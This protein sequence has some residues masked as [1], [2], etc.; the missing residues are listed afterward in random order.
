MFAE[1]SGGY[2]HSKD[3]FHWEL[4]VTSE[5]KNQEAWTP[6]AFVMN[7]TLYWHVN[8]DERV[9]R[10]TDPGSGHWELATS[11]FERPG[12]DQTF[13]Y[14]P[15]SRRLFFYVGSHFKDPITGVEYD[16]GTWKWKGEPTAV[17]Q[18]NQ[19]ENGWEVRS[20][21]NDPSRGLP[22]C[23]EG[24]W[25]S[26]LGSTLY[27][28]YA[29]PVVE[30]KSYCDAV[31]TAPASSPLGPFK[32]QADN[33]LTMKQRGFICATGAGSIFEDFHGNLWH[34][35]CG[36]IS[37]HFVLERLLCLTPLN[38][39][40]DGTLRGW[41]GWGDWPMRLPTKKWSRPEEIKVPGVLLSYKAKVTVSSTA[42]DCKV[43]KAWDQD[44]C[45]GCHPE[46][47]VDEEVRTWWAAATNRTGEWL[48]VD[49]GAVC[50]IT[51]I[52][53]N[54]ADEGATTVGRLPGIFYQYVV[55]GSRD[56]VSFTKILD[57]SAQTEDHPHQYC[58]AEASARFI[59]VT[60]KYTPSGKVS[61][62]GLRIFGLQPGVPAPAAATE[63]KAQRLADRRAA[64]VSWRPVPGAVGYNVRFGTGATRLWQDMIV[65]EVT[66]VTIRYLNVHQ[67]YT[68]TVDA[69]NLGGIT[70]GVETAVA[71]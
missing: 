26:R 16:P 42:S 41:N 31:Y 18:H 65:Y 61:I 22:S 8:F 37:V 44:N 69:Y 48:Q 62:S 60:N 58:E 14:Y 43:W 54:F 29:G 67:S 24:A 23:V 66:E 2:F 70:L 45:G 17:I 52:Q 39:E 64:T 71:P 33:P 25:A 40:P 12:G 50:D 27:L 49:L 35:A 3:M 20:S 56:G 32:L 6:A 68:F 1:T 55:E 59:R 11:K 51:G 63:I 5:L 21:T 38:L 7:D 13:I 10:T 36:S 34:A 4:V 53:V 57:F 19:A 15:E 47:A 30:V 28:I 46:S 9:Y